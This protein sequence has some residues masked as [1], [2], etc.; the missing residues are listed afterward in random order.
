MD[1]GLKTR[2]GSRK[3]DLSAKEQDSDGHHIAMHQD[4]NLKIF[5]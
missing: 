4:H 2:S 3:N 5:E 1:D